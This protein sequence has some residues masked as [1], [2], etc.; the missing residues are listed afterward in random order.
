MAQP[1]A[2]EKIAQ[3]VTPLPEQ[4]SKSRAEPLEP[5]GMAESLNKKPGQLAGLFAKIVGTV[6]R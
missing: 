2:S 1:A 3:R 4:G 5:V 6:C